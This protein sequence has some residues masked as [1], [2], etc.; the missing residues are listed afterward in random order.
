ML[1]TSDSILPVSP[2]RRGRGLPVPQV[3]AMTPANIYMWTHNAPGP[4]PAEPIPPAGHAFRGVMQVLLL[5]IL[6]GLAHPPA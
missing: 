5:S 2:F 6:W 4:G 3:F 1:S